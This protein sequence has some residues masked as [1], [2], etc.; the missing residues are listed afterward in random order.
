M[1]GI[2]S[3]QVTRWLA[4]WADGDRAALGHLMPLV[5]DE[6]HRLAARYMRGERAGHTLQATALVHETFLELLEQRRVNW[7][8]RAHFFGVAAT[9]MR[10]VLLHHIEHKH[11]AK[12]GGGWQRVEL[13]EGLGLTA[14][15][16]EDLMTIDRAL[17][18]LET[19]APRQ[20]RVV[21][22]RFFVGFTV[23]ETAKA[24]D[25]S[26]ITVK[27]EWRMAKAWL[28]REMDKRPMDQQP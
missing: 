5:Y 14:G 25:I 7:Q 21:E 9:L 22:L 20:C 16:M 6:M 12:R 11:A 2:V 26:P 8:S 15:Q 28:E 27:R 3:D 4:A 23:E 17:E 13:D 1:P 19:L 10:R 24:L 18:T